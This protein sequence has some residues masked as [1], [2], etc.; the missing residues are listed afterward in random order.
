[1]AL[2]LATFY[3]LLAFSSWSSLSF[4][5]NYWQARRIRLPILCTPIDPQNLLWVLLFEGPL[6]PILRNILP[7]PFNK[8]IEIN[9]R[10]RNYHKIHQLHK[11]IGEAFI[12]VS[13]KSFR[14]F[15]A[16]AKLVEQLTSRRRD[17]VKPVEV[18]KILEVFGPSVVTTEGDAWSRH[19]KVTSPPF[20]DRVSTLVWREAQAQA[21]DMLGG[22]L[23]RPDG[24]NDTERDT[25]ILALHVLT[26]T[27][28]GSFHKFRGGLQTPVAGYSMTY[29][30]ALSMLMTNIV[31]CVLA[32]KLTLP[33]W[34]LPRKFGDIREAID[35]F[36]RYMA[37]M[38][39]KEKAAIAM[40][41]PD[42]NN[43]MSS[44]IRASEASRAVDKGRNAALSDEEIFGNLF[45]HNLA[46]HETTSNTL[47]FA[48]ALLAAHPNWQEWVAE[49]IDQVIGS[50][51]TE[52]DGYERAFPRLK[53]CL[54]VMV[55]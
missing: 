33:T 4:L 51:G 26:A 8:W 6:T 14:V 20:N 3:L 35:N 23:E 47:A 54:A 45:S 11:E 43:L 31:I 46:G 1:M 29:R 21:T 48:I 44:L 39:K 28:L 12:I 17:F 18:Y 49:E 22:W 32:A 10:D 5:H 19:R 24:I 27:G 9:S 50:D 37:E 7:P 13:P 53:R 42:G 25:M 16:E 40:G 55:S 38:L 15:V 30:D 36:K 2:I 41:K 34:M 52:L